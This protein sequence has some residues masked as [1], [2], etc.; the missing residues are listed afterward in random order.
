MNQKISNISEQET[1]DAR[2]D[3]QE[4]RRTKVA[5]KRIHK[6]FACAVKISVEIPFL[7]TMVFAALDL[8]RSGMFLA[9]PDPDA[10][11][12]NFEGNLVRTGKHLTL[13]FAIL[14][15]GTR[16]QCQV[17]ARIN[18]VTESGIA[19]EFINRNPWQLAELIDLFSRAFPETDVD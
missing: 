4:Q 16:H 9:F 11:K 17:R 13:L 15:N 18:R 5:A 19:V 2:I 1:S 10:A 7:P 12:G 14:I 8:S 6:R 3:P